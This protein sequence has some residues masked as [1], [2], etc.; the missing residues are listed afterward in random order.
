MQA[1]VVVATIAQAGAMGGRGGGG[2]SNLQRFEAHDPPALK[3]GGDL[4]VAGHCFR[5]VRKDTGASDKRKENQPFSSSKKKQKTYAS[6]KSQ[7]QGRSH[8]DQGQGQ[9]FKGRKHFKAPI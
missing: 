2:S 1:G 7:G 3:E 6:H 4:M 8:Q 5:L 9:S